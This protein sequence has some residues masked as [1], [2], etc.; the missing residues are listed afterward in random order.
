MKTGYIEFLAMAPG[1]P[2]KSGAG[3]QQQASGP[4]M[5]ISLFPFILIFV[6]FY[7]LIIAPQRKQQKEHEKMLGGLK[8]GDK[9]ITSGGMHGVIAE[10]KEAEKVVVVQVAQN[11][12]VDISRSSITGVKRDIETPQPK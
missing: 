4:G 5:L 11:V 8:R 2:G 1:V 9:V 10:F 6:V 12:R 3:G 7:F